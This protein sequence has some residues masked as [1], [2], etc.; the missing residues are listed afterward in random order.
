[1]WRLSGAHHPA[2][3]VPTVLVW[4]FKRLAFGPGRVFPRSQ[5]KKDHDLWSHMIR[6]VMR[7]VPGYTS[8]KELWSQEWWKMVP[9]SIWMS[10]LIHWFIDPVDR[11]RS[12]STV[13]KDSPT[14]KYIRYRRSMRIH[15]QRIMVDRRWWSKIQDNF[16]VDF[17]D[18]TCVNFGKSVSRSSLQGAS[19]W[20][21]LG[22]V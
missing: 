9:T 15:L 18:D 4:R 13:D 10:I 20:S 19:D 8:T 16:V 2:Y 5:G 3:W 6:E 22:Q 7:N 14:G 1:V 12:I 21:I 17:I 11:S